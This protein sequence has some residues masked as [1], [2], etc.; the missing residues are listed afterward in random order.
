MRRFLTLNLIL[1][2]LALGC[3]SGGQG[4]ASC[5]GN[6]A[7]RVHPT[8]AEPGQ[9]LRVDGGGF[10]ADCVDNPT[11]EKGPDR[12]VRVEFRQGSRA[13]SLATVAADPGDSIELR[14]DVPSDAKPGEARVIAG[15]NMG[16]AE[17]R[18]LVV[19]GTHR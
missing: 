7:L 16:I 15:G 18:L 4:E 8:C 11:A 2:M 9:T 6:L 13:W 1:C 3:T 14:P 17:D 12:D 10:A 19:D 5:V